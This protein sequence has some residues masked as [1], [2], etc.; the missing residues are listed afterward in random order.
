VLRILRHDQGAE[1]VVLIVEGR[2]VTEWADVLEEECLALIGSHLR[3]AL[4]L[5]GVSFIGRRGVDVLRRLGRGGVE[6]EGCSPLI[7]ETLEQEGIAVS[8]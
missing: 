1:R 8:R 7:A 5:S 4:D 2:I 3:V 6:I